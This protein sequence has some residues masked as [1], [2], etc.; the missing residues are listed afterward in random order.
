MGIGK[1]NACNLLREKAIRPFSGRVLQ[2]GRQDIGWCPPG[3]DGPLKDE[4]FF[5][6]LGFETVHSCDVSDYE[7]PNFVIDLNKAMAGWA[8][9]LQ[10]YDVI[11]DGGTLEHVF[12][13]P[14]ALANIHDMLAVGGCIIHANPVN[15]YVDHGFYQLSPTFFYD[16]YTANG[17]R[18]EVCYLISTNIVESNRP[19][20]WEYASS[21]LDAT[22]R[23]SKLPPRVDGAEMWDLFFVA[24]KLAES[25]CGIVPQQR[26]MNDL[27]SGKQVNG[28]GLRF[29]EEL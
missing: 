13:L 12:H 18:V 27:W 22:E 14:N 10:N 11:Y 26:S 9:G 25:T 16:Y 19:H 17:Y 2:L 24:T 1:V 29:V 21:C 20:V 28:G 23:H 5:R 7:K 4:P 3:Y 15:G 8:L 6:W